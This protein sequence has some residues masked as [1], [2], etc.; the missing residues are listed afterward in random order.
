[1][2]KIFIL[3]MSFISFVTF[4]Q[5]KA[6]A[7][8]TLGKDTTIIQHF[9]FADNKYKTVFIM[10]TGGITKCEATGTLDEKGDLLQVSSLNYRLGANGNWELTSRGENNF[11]GDSSIYIAINPQGTIVSRRSFSGNGIVANGMDIAS[12]YTFPYMGFYAPKKIADTNFH[13]QLSFNG[14]RKY[15]VAREAKD[16]IRIGSNLMGYLVNTIDKKGRLQHIDGVGSSL[17]I[18]GKIDRE[19]TDVALL[20]E[21]ARRKNAS[22]TQVVRTVRD[23]AVIMLGN[24]KIEVDYWRPH[25]RGREIFGSVVPWDRIWR[26]GANNATQLRL[27]ND[28]TIGDKKLSKGIY[29]IWSFLTEAKWELII[30]KNANAWGTDHDP[31]ADIFRIP[32]KVEK[33][34]EPVEILKI[35]FV[36]ENERKAAM[37]IEWDI[38]KAVVAVATE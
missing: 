21:Y 19:K 17:N 4:A 37:V 10:F 11:N 13:R 18:I 31:A 14:F 12:F 28:I 2:K 1:M 9:E 22:G 38:Y 26:T 16:K 29:G 15:M 23:T 32:Y 30:N 33:I 7:Y 5:D 6:I 34:N 27:S 35:T 25:K 24:T 8:Y 3:L 20:D 36:K